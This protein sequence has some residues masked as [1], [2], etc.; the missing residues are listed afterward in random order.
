MFQ[1]HGT[2]QE[3]ILPAKCS[4]QK[5]TYGSQKQSVLTK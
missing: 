1:A 2:G 4:T 3:Q 5:A